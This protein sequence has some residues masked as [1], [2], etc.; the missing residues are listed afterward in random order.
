MSFIA[1]LQVK[2]EEHRNAEILHTSYTVLNLLFDAN[3]IIS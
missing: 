3:T 1:S 2:E